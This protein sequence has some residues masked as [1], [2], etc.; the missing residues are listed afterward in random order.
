MPSHVM[1]LAT[2]G[3]WGGAEN[4]IAQ[5]VAHFHGLGYQV[6]LGTFADGDGTLLRKVEGTP[7]IETFSL[8]I[9]N[10]TPYRVLE[11]HERLAVGAP[12]VIVAHLFHT[13]ITARI[14]GCLFRR[15]PVISVYH[16]S[17]QPPLRCAIDRATMGLSEYFVTVSEDGAAFARDKLNVPR[18]KL[19]TI[20][21]GV[22]I[23]K[24]TSPALPREEVRKSF[25]FGE[26][27]FVIGCVAR[28]HN[29]KDHET[30]L[31]AFRLLRQRRTNARLLLVG[32]GDE[33]GKL[34]EL[35]A[36]LRLLGDVIFAGFRSDLPELYAAMD[37]TCYTSRREGFGIAALESMAVGLPVV[38][39]SAP[40]LTTFLRHKEN[41]LLAPVGDAIGIASALEAIMTQPELA[42][43]ITKSAK[44]EVK[45]KFSLARVLEQYKELVEDITG[46]AQPLAH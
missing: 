32:K 5:T 3:S 45:T 15:V 34:R 16:S 25:G 41:S 8:G 30:L 37:A 2:T 11:L 6:T 12:D 20:Y 36:G 46:P 39:T 21:Y 44:E 43:A 10:R 35:A 7:E 29:V 9:T 31:R 13:Y 24:L 27:D 26:G 19:R 17:W 18:H 42:Q 14:L 33:A 38:A 23:E 40:G 28:L 1:V 22:D 4:I